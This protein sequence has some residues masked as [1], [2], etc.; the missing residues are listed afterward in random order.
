MM[1]ILQVAWVSR[2]R[3]GGGRG[4]QI[5]QS[6]LSHLSGLSFEGQGEAERVILERRLYKPWI[7]T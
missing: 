5:R 2:S 4:T 6:V 1:F 3:A 7:R